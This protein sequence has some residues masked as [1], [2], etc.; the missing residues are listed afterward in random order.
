MG[1]RTCFF[2]MG[3]VLVTFSHQT[4]CHNVAA[5]CHA[6]LETV[7]SLLL[8]DE[9]LFQ[10]ECSHIT[11]DQFHATVQKELNSSVTAEALKIAVSDIFELN[12]SIV[13][14]LE[15]LKSSEVRLVLLSNTSVTHL[16]F[17]RDR[18]NVLDLFDDMTTSFAAGALKPDAAIYQHALARAQA[19]PSECFFTDDIEAYV[20]AAR[21]FGI[22]A[23]VYTDTERTRRQLRELGVPV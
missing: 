13:P 3:N 4:I 16:N 1:I 15:D 17:I 10:L 22:H 9:L 8:K 18:F 5:A 19:A 20:T 12:D 7:T 14:L 6:E 21:R 11:E 2:D 23:E